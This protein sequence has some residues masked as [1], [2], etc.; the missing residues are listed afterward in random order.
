MLGALRTLVG[1][2]EPGEGEYALGGA[3][4][5]RVR[6][7]AS[8]ERE[9]L[10]GF[11]EVEEEAALLCLLLPRL[12]PLSLLSPGSELCLFHGKRNLLPFPF[13]TLT[14]RPSGD[15]LPSVTSS[16]KW[17]DFTGTR[18]TLYVESGV[19]EEGREGT[20]LLLLLRGARKG[21]MSSPVMGKLSMVPS[22]V[23]LN[24]T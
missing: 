22:L 1:L 17:T 12:S 6:L 5:D 24:P 14:L 18:G 10:S 16:S 23:R 21:D 11:F 13:P 20:L 9:W 2:S 8:E 7:C 3:S 4:G 15:L 19:A